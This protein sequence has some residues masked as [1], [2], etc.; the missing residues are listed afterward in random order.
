MY[1][2]NA[3][4]GFIWSPNSD[5]LAVQASIINGVTGSV[6]K[7]YFKCPEPASRCHW[8][9]FTTLGVCSNF[10]DVT[11]VAVPKCNHTGLGL[12]CTY[13][14]PGMPY[15][16]DT[17]AMVMAWNTESDGGF[18]PSMLFQSRVISHGTGA[19]GG[20]F[21]SFMA[22]KVTDSSSPYPKPESIYGGELHPPATNV[23][24]STFSWCAKTFYNTTG[25]QADIHVDSMSF[26]PL[27]LTDELF[28]DNGTRT[29]CYTYVSELTRLNFYI[30]K[31]AATSLPGYMYTIL[32]ATV[33][34]EIFRPDSSLEHQQLQI[35]SA[36]QNSNLEMVITNIAETLTN[37]IRSQHPG[38]N[39][40]ASVAMG[41][42]FFE[43]TYICVRWGWMSL[44][45][46]EVLLTTTLFVVTIIITRKQPLLKQSLI[47]LLM[48]RLEGWPDDELNVLEPQTQEKLD[49][50]A[51]KMLAQL[52]ANDQDHL[53]FFK[54]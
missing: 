1:I 12:N 44:P 39:F 53:R 46:A 42:A 24:S 13:S 7:P 3:S 14:F 17:E 45:I 5:L 36:L 40:N 6:F 2:T 43:E 37:Q 20:P 50:L 35:G 11:N 47:A 33:Y 34:H 28:F 21:A 4:L 48:N 30:S 51:K 25:S 49:V 18:D 54:S 27:N 41:E 38:D 16:D 15:I 31:M 19:N 23:Y 52:K 9:N 32:S 29:T 26:E 10:T 22:V 8:G